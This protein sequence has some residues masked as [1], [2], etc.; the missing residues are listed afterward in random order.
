MRYRKYGRRNRYSKRKGYRAGR[1]K[2]D[3]SVFKKI[4]WKISL[5][6][7]PISYLALRHLSGELANGDPAAQLMQIAALFSQYVIPVMLIFGAISNYTF[8]AKRK[9]LLNKVRESD[10]LS[11]ALS[12][13]TWQEFEQAVGQMFREKGYSV[14]EGAGTRDGGVDLTL[15]RRNKTFLVQCKHW[16][17]GNVGVSVV[18]EL[19]GVMSMRKADGAYVVAS[20]NFTKDAAEFAKKANVEL[21]GLSALKKHLG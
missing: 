1:R 15:Q 10:H 8:I 13:L 11:Y 18:R 14:N 2:G 21:V 16:R 12:S 4:N 19:Y 9:R 20:G 7:A 3:S 6:A 17:T 5:I